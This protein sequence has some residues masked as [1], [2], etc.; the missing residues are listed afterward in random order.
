MQRYDPG[1]T[2]ELRREVKDPDGVLTDTTVV[3]EYLTPGATVWSGASVSHNGVG[4][5]DAVI[6]ELI[7]GLYKYRWT[8]SGAVAD[9]LT[10]RFY[11]ADEGD[12]LPPL[13]PFDRLANKLGATVDDFDDVEF[14]RGCY[15]LDEASEMIRDVAGKTWVD[16]DTGAL[17]EVPRR[18][19]RICVAAAARAF[20]NP[21]GLAQRTIGDSSKSYDRTGREGGEVV[22]L[23]DAE[24][25]D[26]VKA[27][28]GGVGF[29]SVTLTSPYSGEAELDTWELV[30]AE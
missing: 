26:I 25:A 22:Y 8:T 3:F 28:G 7:D 29:Q 13:A 24:K 6:T 4:I 20:N 1:D 15:L 27:A 12:E 16:E 19:A 14:D 5:Y 17:T 23:T 11:V 18:V 9:V 21:E 30:T 10:G 2:A